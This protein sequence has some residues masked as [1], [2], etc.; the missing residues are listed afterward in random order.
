[1]EIER[2]PLIHSEQGQVYFGT[3]KVSK[4][5]V[6]IKQINIGDSSYALIK[7]LQVF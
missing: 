1:M 4:K 6:V 2:R 3:D 5:K 7:E